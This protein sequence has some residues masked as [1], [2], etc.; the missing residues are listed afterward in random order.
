MEAPNIAKSQSFLMVSYQQGFFLKKV[1]VV[2]KKV[3]S[4]GQL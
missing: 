4:I 2:K 1:P 3:V